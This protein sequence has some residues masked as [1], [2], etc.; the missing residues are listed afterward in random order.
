MV[1]YNPPPGTTPYKPNRSV[2]AIKAALET[3]TGYQTGK[4]QGQDRQR[5]MQLDELKQKLLKTQIGQSEAATEKA[6]RAP[7]LSP[8]QEA[9]KRI[10]DWIDT[11]PPEVRDRISKIELKLEPPAAQP[12]KLT[13]SDLKFYTERGYTPAEAKFIL[14]IKFGLTK[15]PKNLK[16]LMTELS[17]AQTVQNKTREV[18]ILG[19]LG[20]IKDQETWDLAE[21]R[22][23][24]LRKAAAAIMTKALTK[25]REKAGK[26]TVTSDGTIRVVSPKGVH[27]EIQKRDWGHWK[28]KGYKKE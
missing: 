3:I 28:K 24:E 7:V 19:Q 21:K 17:Q 16:D 2:D 22:I 6:R 26:K 8:A 11:Q 20:E 27:G 5:G 10:N 15:E 18:G 4:I 25:A 9:Q 13:T 23:A 1:V 14:D 12:S